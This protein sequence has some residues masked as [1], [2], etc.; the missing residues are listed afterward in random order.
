MVVVR[1]RTNSPC[2]GTSYYCGSG[3]ISHVCKTAIPVYAD[4]KPVFDV[5]YSFGFGRIARV[6][7][8]AILGD[9]DE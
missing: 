1:I 7:V 5:R 8:Y 3:R 9:T 2:L 6:C 4:E